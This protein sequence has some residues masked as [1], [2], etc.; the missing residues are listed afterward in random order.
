VGAYPRD[1]HWDICRSA[2]DADAQRR[3][4]S[5]P[6]PKNDPVAGSSGPMLRLWS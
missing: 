4:A 2:P 5:L 3:M 1:Q 6:F